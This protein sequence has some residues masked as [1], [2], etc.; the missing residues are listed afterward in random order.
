W[1]TAR[2]GIQR[3]IPRSYRGPITRLAAGGR[4]VVG[5]Y[6]HRD[7]TDRRGIG[8]PGGESMRLLARAGLEPRDFEVQEGPREWT[9][10][11]KYL[12]AGYRSG[13]VVDGIPGKTTWR[14]LH[15]AGRVAGMWVPRPG[16]AD[17][18]VDLVDELPESAAGSSF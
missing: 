17:V 5:V 3:Q 12:N 16:D 10:R 11:Q 1:L 14:A 15:D 8:D 4:D 13:L 9:Q 6:G 2:F 7:V 18:I